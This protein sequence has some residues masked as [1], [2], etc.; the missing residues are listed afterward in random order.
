MP[1]GILVDYEWCSGCHSCEMACKVQHNL[2]EGQYGVK[3]TQVGPYNV[4]GDE[5]VWINLPVFTEQCNLCAER[6]AEDKLP[7]CVQHCQ[8]AIMKYGEVD[9]LVEDL[10]RKPKQTL[11]CLEKF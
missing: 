10:K 9:D 6:T 1:K 2:P 3:L 11:F 8:A 7:N 5:W 4:Q